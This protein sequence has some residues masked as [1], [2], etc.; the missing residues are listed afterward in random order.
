MET[1]A[2]ELALLGAIVVMLCRSTDG[3]HQ[4][5][6]LANPDYW[7]LLIWGQQNPIGRKGD[8][9]INLSQSVRTT[10]FFFSSPALA[11]CGG[12]YK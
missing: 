5:L 2:F 4:L 10:M 9:L 11:Q 3:G 8:G 7:N 1:A 12:I 6:E